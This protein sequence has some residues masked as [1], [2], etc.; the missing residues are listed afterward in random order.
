M[1]SI[2]VLQDTFAKQSTVAASQLPD[3]KKYFLKAGIEFE[4]DRWNPTVSNHVKAVPTKQLG[5]YQTWCFFQDHIQIN[6]PDKPKEIE[7]KVPYYSQR[8][9]VQDW[10][11]TCNTSSCAMVAEYL[12]PG[13]IKGSDDYYL[14]NYVNKYGDTTDHSA[15]TAAL[16]ALG[17]DSYFSYQLDYDDL[18]RELEAGR[19]VVIGVL[20][21]GPI[22]QPSGG[23]MIVVIGKYADGYIFNDSWGEGFDY[24]GSNGKQVKYPYQSLNARWLM[25][26]A[27][28]GWGRIFKG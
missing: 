28:T 19:P 4:I 2:K 6:D 25:D 7:L 26:G 24:S 12:K 11:R 27:N 10:W 8:D 20:H 18:D 14:L 15:Q 21:K 3:G 17:I 16:K 13:C 22:T 9:N 5:N 23:H 1:K